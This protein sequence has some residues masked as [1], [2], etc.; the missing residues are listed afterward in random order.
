MWF[1][2]AT[3]YLAG[4]FHQ[5]ISFLVEEGKF[6]KVQLN[7]PVDLPSSAISL[8]G[9]YVIPG[10]I[11]QH[12]HGS[13]GCDFMDGEVE[14]NHR[15]AEYLPSIGVTSFLATT[16]TEEPTVI[17]KALVALE[18]AFFKAEYDEAVK[19]A[20]CLG[21]HLEGPFIS[22]LKKGAHV[23][24]WIKTPNVETYESLVGTHHLPI[25]IVT[26]APECDDSHS[27]IRHLQKNDVIPSVG[28]SQA[29]YGEMQEAV[30]NGVKCVTHCFNA[31]SSV[32]ARDGGVLG[33]ALGLTG[34]YGEIIADGIHVSPENI[35]MF[36]KM[37]HA[38]DKILISD[39]MRARGAKTGN[40]KLGGL[41]AYY[42]GS[43]VVLPD[44]TLAGSA[45]KPFDAIT[46]YA[47]VVGDTLESILPMLTVNPARLLKVEGSKG[48]IAE[49]FDA[50]FL[51][52][53]QNY[54]L[55]MTVCRG[56]I[57]YRRE[58]EKDNSK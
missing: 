38:D 4:Q 40:V 3:V 28:H 14:N 32:T 6:K 48:Q 53:D 18:E 10:F 24:Q 52:L 27:L 1:K 9:K 45:L 58:D 17:A 44:G 5:N 20:H 54:Q 22:P 8:D 50:D 12:I 13:V 21:V 36:H 47:K 26:L 29:T 57:C 2:D 15:I 25:K 11:D 46:H 30:E 31:M 33:A 23:Q 51:I 55:L 49:G 19:G 37:K 35:S 39:A 7:T 16:L 42:D 41:E 34:L 56:I 43:K